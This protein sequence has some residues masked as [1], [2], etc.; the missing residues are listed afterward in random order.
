[1]LDMSLT[2]LD[3]TEES[4]NN[5]GRQVV[6]NI[7][8]PDFKHIFLNSLELPEYAKFLVQWIDY[9]LKSNI[10]LSPVQVISRSVRNQLAY[11]NNLTAEEMAHKSSTE[12]AKMLAKATHVESKADFAKNMKKALSATKRL[13]WDSVKP[14][15]HEK[16]WQGVLHRKD[17]FTRIF[18]IMMEGNA[19]MCPEVDNKENGLIRIFLELF[20]EGYG[21]C[22]LE[23]LP[24]INIKNFPKIEDFI[25]KFVELCNVHYDISRRVRQV[26]YQGNDFQ[27]IEY[28]TQNKANTRILNVI[29]HAP[30]DIVEE[31]NDYDDPPTLLF[32]SD[33][34]VSEEDCEKSSSVD[35]NNAYLQTPQPLNYVPN[36]R[37]FNSGSTRQPGADQ[38]LFNNGSSRQP[39]SDNPK[40]DNYGCISYTLHGKCFK[41]EAC[42]YASM[43]NPAGVQRT[44]KWILAKMN[45]V[46]LNHMEEEEC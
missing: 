32:D 9:E 29:Q 20:D 1:M 21:K 6:V 4:T 41:G 14:L 2:A 27:A 38:R 33:D 45:S 26:P 19:A 13:P 39:G 12:V 7:T 43:H 31:D 35:L 17:T 18:A 8:P 11:S 23:E 10:K 5:A 36:E 22:L 28:P 3:A 15:N 25:T 37:P 44:K 16:F 42:K 34:S 24:K 46:P 40:P 30:Q